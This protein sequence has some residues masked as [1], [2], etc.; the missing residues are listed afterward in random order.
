[1]KDIAKFIDAVTAPTTRK[2]KGTTPERADHTVPALESWRLV[3]GSRTQ[4][5]SLDPVNLTTFAYAALALNGERFA[6]KHFAGRDAQRAEY[7]YVVALIW[8]SH[9]PEWE[10][11]EAFRG[12]CSAIL[13]KYLAQPRI[14]AGVPTKLKVWKRRTAGRNASRK[15]SK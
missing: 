4:V 2:G 15:A 5:L 11:S 14:R 13:H 10:P 12:M 6:P 3:S 9:N 1:M 7:G 8:L